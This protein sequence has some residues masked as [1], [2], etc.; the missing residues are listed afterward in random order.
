MTL[1]TAYATKSFGILTKVTKN[2]GKSADQ[3][4]HDSTRKTFFYDKTMTYQGRQCDP[5]CNKIR[6]DEMAIRES[7]SRLVNAAT[8]ENLP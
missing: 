1:A 5:I 6:T 3:A 4:D 8:L 7:H 2:I